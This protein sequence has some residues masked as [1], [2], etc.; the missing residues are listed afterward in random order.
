MMVSQLQRGTNWN[1][2]LKP[3]RTEFKLCTRSAVLS[4]LPG[5]I[6]EWKWLPSSHTA[7][8]Q[9]QAALCLVYSDYTKVVITLLFCFRKLPRKRNILRSPFFMLVSSIWA[10]SLPLPSPSPSSCSIFPI[11]LSSPTNYLSFP[12]L[13]TC[14]GSG[15]EFVQRFQ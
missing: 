5:W 13:Q 4:F 14:N 3:D 10:G 9:G 7:W 15:E 11:A 2:I 12:L 8:K 6:G 1:H